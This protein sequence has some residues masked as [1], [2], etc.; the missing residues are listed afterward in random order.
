MGVTQ[1]IAR[2]FINFGVG[3]FLFLSGFLTR[4]D[5]WNGSRIRRRIR[6][7]LIPYIVWTLI[8]TLLSRKHENIAYNLLTASSSAQMYYCLVY[9]QIVL[10]TGICFRAL[11]NRI[12]TIL[13]MFASPVS[14]MFKYV[15]VFG[16]AKTPAVV[17]LIYGISFIPW[18]WYYLIGLQIRKQDKHISMKTLLLFWF[19]S[20]LFQIGEGW[21]WFRVGEANCGT[22][23]KFSAWITTTLVCFICYQVIKLRKRN[24]SRMARCLIMIGDYSFG[25]YLCH[26][27]VMAVLQHIPG[28]QG[29]PY[30]TNSLLVLMISLICCL[31]V[32]KIC[33][34]IR[35]GKLNL[36][37]VFGLK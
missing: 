31:V 11:K 34:K 20:I 18:I 10:L 19:I 1:I 16:G 28:Y 25:I 30:I 22:Q 32:D 15:Q 8:Y 13:F 33:Q 14:F 37:K 29:V 35:I 5:T 4:E 6:R 27:A 23:I 24:T 3:V 9:I 36:N 21:I 12:W 26:I 17:N 2:P 7:V